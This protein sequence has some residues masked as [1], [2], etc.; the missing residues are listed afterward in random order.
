MGKWLNV[1]GIILCCLLSAVLYSDHVYAAKIIGLDIL[2][3]NWVEDIVPLPMDTSPIEKYYAHRQENFFIEKMAFSPAEDRIAF[4][5]NQNSIW[6]VRSDGTGLACLVCDQKPAD[7]PEWSKDGK[8]IIFMSG[9]GGGGKWFGSE[10]LIGIAPDGT[11]KR[12]IG[13]FNIEKPFP[14][15]YPLWRYSP[16]GQYMVLW[17]SVPRPGEERYGLRDTYIHLVRVKDGRSVANLKTTSSI[18]NIQWFPNGKEVLIEAL[19]G[20]ISGDSLLIFFSIT[21]KKRVIYPDV[22][23]DMRPAIH[24]SGQLIACCDDYI[25]HFVSKDGTKNYQILKSQDS[26]DYMIWTTRGDR[27]VFSLGNKIYFLKLK[28]QVP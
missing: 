28:K 23:Q 15:P 20:R 1:C 5:V 19:G 17:K 2:D 27:L 9:E 26:I 12:T 8:E 14:P 10:I 6:T 25:L 11:R 24:P 3:K 4:V 13:T 22:H 7:S 18:F 16:D 21:G